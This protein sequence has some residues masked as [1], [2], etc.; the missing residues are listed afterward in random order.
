MTAWLMRVNFVDDTVASE[1][2]NIGPLC[3]YPGNMPFRHQCSAAR[4]S[5]MLARLE[6]GW[7]GFTESAILCPA[8]RARESLSPVPT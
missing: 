6:E 1:K 8:G 7:L 2:P 5:L 4:H 3:W